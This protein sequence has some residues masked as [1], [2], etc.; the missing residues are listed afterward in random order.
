M[1]IDKNTR[2]RVG[3]NVHVREFDGEMVLLD[4]DRGEYFGLDA[5][6]CRV[7]KSLAEGKS[8]A[9]IADDLAPEHEVEPERLLADL[10][11]LVNDLLARGLVTPAG[12]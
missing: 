10:L 7:W 11:A 5:L 12:S 9:E 1:S 6:G 8:L 4:L 3:K 2:V